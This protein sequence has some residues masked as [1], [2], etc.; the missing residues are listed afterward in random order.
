MNK[1]CQVQ[2]R[3]IHSRPGEYSTGADVAALSTG[4]YILY[5]WKTGS[6]SPGHFMALV[7]GEL[8]CDSYSKNRL[9]SVKPLSENNVMKMFYGCKSTSAIMVWKIVK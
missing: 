5:A 7:D 9:C 1:I 8:R 3:S 4:S 6:E 2:V